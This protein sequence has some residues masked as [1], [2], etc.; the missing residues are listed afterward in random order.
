MVNVADWS[1]TP[2]NNSTVDGVNIAENCPAGNMNAMGRAIMA[3]VRSMFDALPNL[4]DYLKRDGSEA[5][6][7]DLKRNTRGAYLHNASASH[8]S[9]RIF[10]QADGSPLPSGPQN[11]DQLLEY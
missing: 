6:T 7:G 2:S 10:I 1:A 3:G 4:A 5:T 11:G 8:G 9:G